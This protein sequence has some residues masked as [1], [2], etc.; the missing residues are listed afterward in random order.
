MYYIV[1]GIAGAAVAVLI[2]AFARSNFY[3][4]A[5]LMPLFPT[6]ALFTHILSYKEGGVEQVK[7]V[8]LFG[9]Y[10]VIPYLAYVAII[11]FASERMRFEYTVSIGM[12]C[13]FL[14]AGL[15]YFWWSKT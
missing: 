10:S 6:F 15:L 2:A 11:Y 12:L 9:I 14:S 8:A 5:G 3:I 7:E 13:W 1:S 4:L